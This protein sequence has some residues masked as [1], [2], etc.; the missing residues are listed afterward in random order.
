MVVLGRVVVRL[1]VVDEAGRVVELVEEAGFATGLAAEVAVRDAEEEVVVFLSKAEPATLD[2]RSTVDEDLSG[3]RVEV[4]PAMDM[5]F[6]VPEMPRFSSPELAIDRG[7]SSAELLTE[8][9]DRW[10]EVVEVL[11]GFRVAVVAVVV[12]RVGGLF[13]VLLEVLPRV[14]DEAVVRGVVED[15]GRLAVAVPDTGR[16]D[17]DAVPG[18]ALAGDAGAFSFE[19]SGLDLFTSSLP[20]A[21]VESTGVAGGAGSA[22]ASEGVGT[23]SST[24]A[25]VS[26]VLQSA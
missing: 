21:T 11:R 20:D 22:S 3:V 2:L 10:D 7:F 5:R 9:R 1:A 13:N 14:V 4:V 6:A 25:I 15:V 24:D 12:G 26:S 17:A 23:G 18:E 8:A 19:A 16:L